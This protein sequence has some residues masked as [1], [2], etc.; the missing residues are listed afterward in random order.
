MGRQLPGQAGE[1][2]VGDVQGSFAFS[3]SPVDQAHGQIFQGQRRHLHHQGLLRVYVG[4]YPG[5][6]LLGGN[7]HGELTLNH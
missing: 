1:T 4:G 2:Q 7:L 6:H 5:G 3:Y